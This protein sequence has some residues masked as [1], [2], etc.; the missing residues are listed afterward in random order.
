METQKQNKKTEL[1]TRLMRKPTRNWRVKTGLAKNLIFDK[2]E[3]E[4]KGSIE[5]FNTGETHKRRA[6]D[7]TRGKPDRTRD[8]KPDNYQNKTGNAGE[9]EQ[10]KQKHMRFNKTGSN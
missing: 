10:Q 7:Q 9:P 3:T 6:G 5:I 2:V 8:V 4:T 1:Q